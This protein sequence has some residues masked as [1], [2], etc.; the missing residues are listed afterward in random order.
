MLFC[1]LITTVFWTFQDSG[2]FRYLMWIWIFQTLQYCRHQYFGCWGICEYSRILDL[3]VFFNNRAY[4]CGFIIMCAFLQNPKHTLTGTE[5]TTP[6][7]THSEMAGDASKAEPKTL[8][9]CEAQKLLWISVIP[10]YWRGAGFGVC[11]GGQRDRVPHC[12]SDLGHPHW[13]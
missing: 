10:C 3:T 2:H 7:H 1:P 9:S 8:K 5:T 11:V 13:D 12:C 4:K 6:P